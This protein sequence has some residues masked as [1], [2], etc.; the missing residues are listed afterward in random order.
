[1][2]NIP[3]HGS[4]APGTVPESKITF[5]LPPTGT[6]TQTTWGVVLPHGTTP[7]TTVSGT[8][9][10]H[11]PTHVLDYIVLVYD[12]A[13]F[14]AYTL[15]DTDIDDWLKRCQHYGVKRFVKGYWWGPTVDPT[16]RNRYE[17][18]DAVLIE[19]RV[20]NVEMEAT[21]KRSK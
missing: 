12:G 13:R 7:L 3:F 6:N 2:T 15:T 11:Q 14:D 9:V 20:V 18:G 10:A 16:Y 5:T 19:G 17:K 4:F 1:M 21:W 8:R